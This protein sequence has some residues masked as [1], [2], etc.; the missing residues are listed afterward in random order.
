MH[1]FVKVTPQKDEQTELTL[2]GIQIDLPKPLYT[3][4]STPLR[5]TPLSTGPVGHAN[6]LTVQ[7]VRF[8][9]P[10]SDRPWRRLGVVVQST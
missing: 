7:F 4:Y 9:V 3:A 6:I 8:G 10:R 1:I 5:L 2:T